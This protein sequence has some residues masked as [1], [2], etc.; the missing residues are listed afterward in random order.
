M[1]DKHT[2]PDQSQ[3]V[4]NFIFLNGWF[5]ESSVSGTVE[6]SRGA[7]DKARLTSS[8]AVTGANVSIIMSI[9]AAG[10]GQLTHTK[11]SWAVISSDEN[12]RSFG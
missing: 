9:A 10:S 3:F 6:T 1:K 7:Y 8:S 11:F 12:P 2:E 5:D 4:S